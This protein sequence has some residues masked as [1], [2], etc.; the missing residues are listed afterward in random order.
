M[1]LAT[2]SLQDLPGAEILR[3]VV[4]NCPTKILLAN[5]A[6]DG[7]F[8]G[9]V[10]RLTPTEQNKVRQLRSK[11][12]F[13]LKREGL[14]KTLNLNVDPKSYWLFTTNPFE[15]KRRQEL[16]EKVGLHAALEILSGGS[17]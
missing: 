14:S 3:P 10:L 5:P 2:Q 13:L 9:E 12:Q 8:Y 17:Q 11:R 6:L 4:D 16:I 1:I 15:A 7:D